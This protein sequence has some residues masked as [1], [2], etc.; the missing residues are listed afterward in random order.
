MLNN[1]EFSSDF[2]IIDCGVEEQWVY[3]IEVEDNHNFFGNNVCVHNSA[4]INFSDFVSTFLKNR[5]ENEVVDA[6]SKV[7]ETKF[8]DQIKIAIDDICSKM[9]A[10]ENHLDMKREAIGQAVFVAKKRYIMR[11]HDSE[12]VRYAT[13]KTKIV[14]LEAVRST[15]PE[16]C[17]KALKET[18][19]TIFTGGEESVIDKV[20]HTQTEFKKL[21]LYDIGMPTGVRDM[22]K[23]LDSAGNWGSGA[24]AHVKA[25]I[26]FNKMLS[27]YSVGNKYE[28]IRDGEKVKVVK[29]KMP[30]PTHNDAIAFPSVL[31][32]EFKLNKYVDYDTQFEKTY[33]DAVKRVTDAIGWKH[34]RSV[35]LEDFF[36]E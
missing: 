16:F 10:F 32:E 30:N 27:K 8:Q 29:L 36:G 22:G 2:D 20:E 24:P 3:D 26:T 23:Y 7:C 18:F 13:P 11:V 14:G 17:R 33:L 31:P 1:V 34:D 5:P 12:G 4:Y 28:S 9:N 21:P 25:S 15:T 19:E 35:S 6:L